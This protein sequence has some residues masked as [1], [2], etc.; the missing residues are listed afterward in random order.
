MPAEQAGILGFSKPWCVLSTKSF[1][2][3]E[4]L[5]ARAQSLPVLCLFIFT[6]GAATVGAHPQVPSLIVDLIEERAAIPW[7]AELR[8]ASSHG[9]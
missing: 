8:S 3:G 4:P 9:R 5:A 7:L 2:F 6:I 1:L